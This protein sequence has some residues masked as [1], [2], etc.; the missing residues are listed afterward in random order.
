MIRRRRFAVPIHSGQKVLVQRAFKQHIVHLA[1][2][3]GE[4]RLKRIAEKMGRAADPGLSAVL[5]HLPEHGK[6]PL[7]GPRI[8][9]GRRRRGGGPQQG[10]GQGAGRVFTRALGRFFPGGHDVRQVGP[11]TPF[12]LEAQ[13]AFID[14]QPQMDITLAR[15][16]GIFQHDGEQQI[17][18]VGRVVRARMRAKHIG[19]EFLRRVIQQ[20]TSDQA[21]FPVPGVEQAQMT[22]RLGQSFGR[23]GIQFP[24]MRGQ[25]AA[26]LP[27]RAAH[28]LRPESPMVRRKF[29][30]FLHPQGCRRAAQ[31]AAQPG[32][33]RGPCRQQ[34][35]AVTVH[36][37]AMQTRRQIRP[38]GP[39]VCG[40]AFF[41]RFGKS[42]LK[43]RVAVSTAQGVSHGHEP[44][45]GGHKKI[46][47]HTEGRA[48][49]H[50]PERENQFP[51][52]CQC[53]RHKAYTFANPGSTPRAG[54]KAE[55]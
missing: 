14:A 26:L 49:R 43:V 23:A 20:Q 31:G 38:H 13:N 53:F 45:C 39:A 5:L 42:R 28:E 6:G 51:Y 29:A 30:A 37:M 24:H 10:Q 35:K 11:A 52:N 15:R 16:A 40:S 2:Q 21:A 9:Q 3:T 47:P 46:R 32:R 44:V 48:L 50:G 34:V 1:E 8:L 41:Q 33:R 36:N 19:S 17:R 4:G 27:V 25:G 18:R 55:C 7:G 22:L 54:K 12:A